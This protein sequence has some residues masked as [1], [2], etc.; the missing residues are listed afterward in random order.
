MIESQR[1][2]NSESEEP[3]QNR[4]I[5]SPD[6]QQPEKTDYQ[7]NQFR[8]HNICKDCTDEETVLALK[9]GPASRTV[10]PD[11]KRALYD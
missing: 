10:M 6:N 5:F 2:N 7:D 3:A 4:F 8:R 1:E 11:V 9:Q